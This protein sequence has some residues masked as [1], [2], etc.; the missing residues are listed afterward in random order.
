MQM[1][2][3]DPDP[4]ICHNFDLNPRLFKQYRYRTGTGTGTGTSNIINF[5]NVNFF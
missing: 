2:C 5:F 1:H 3:I 4:E